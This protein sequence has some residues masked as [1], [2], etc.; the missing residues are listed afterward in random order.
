[1]LVLSRKS[2]ESVSIG[3]GIEVTVVAVCGNQVRLGFT[4]PRNI[5]IERTEITN[6]VRVSQAGGNLALAR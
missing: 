4:A 3:R 2:G 5:P 1:M 6:R